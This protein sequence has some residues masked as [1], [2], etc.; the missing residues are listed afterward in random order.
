MSG[1]EPKGDCGDLGKKTT[2]RYRVWN[3]QSQGHLGNTIGRLFAHLGATARKTAFTKEQ[4]EQKNWPVTFS[5]PAPQY[6]ANRENKHSI[7][8]HYL[9]TRI[10]PTQSSE[11]APL[12]HTCLSPSVARPSSVRLTQTPAHSMSSDGGVLQTLYSSCSSY[13]PHFI[14]RAGHTTFRAGTKSRPQQSVRAF[15]GDWLKG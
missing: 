7:D 9:L 2:H 14:N 11:T 4:R 6:R 15:A 8:T 12:K 3:Q 5:S 10:P 13:G 1:I